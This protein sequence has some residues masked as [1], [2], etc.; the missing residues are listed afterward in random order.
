MSFLFYSASFSGEGIRKH[1]IVLNGCPSKVCLKG[2]LACLTQYNLGHVLH[3]W[4]CKIEGKVR[5]TGARSEPA[6]NHFYTTLLENSCLKQPHFFLIKKEPPLKSGA[7]RRQTWRWLCWVFEVWLR[8]IIWSVHCKD[9]LHTIYQSKTLN[10]KSLPSWVGHRRP[11]LPLW[12]GVPFFVKHGSLT[13]EASSAC[14][15]DHHCFPQERR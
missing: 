13:T 14:T 1:L 11:C 9:V 2:L 10:G 12:G 15:W 5:A 7:R 8:L 6:E 3:M 4:T